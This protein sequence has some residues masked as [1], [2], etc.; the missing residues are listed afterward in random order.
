[1]VVQLSA[2]LPLRAVKPRREN[3]CQSVNTAQS[4]FNWR[5]KNEKPP[6]TLT[7]L[8]QPKTELEKS[9]SSSSE[10]PRRAATAAF[11]KVQI[12]L[13]GGGKVEN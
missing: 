8:E 1:M 9:S 4:I 2:A 6:L 7:Q 10:V 11:Q 12:T 3:K 5:L 13:E